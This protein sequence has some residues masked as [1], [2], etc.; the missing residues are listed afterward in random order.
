MPSVC[1]LA[2]SLYTETYGSVSLIF[3]SVELGML[4]FS[5]WWKDLLE[6]RLTGGVRDLLVVL[7]E[8]E[9]YWWNKRLPGGER[10][11]LVEIETYDKDIHFQAETVAYW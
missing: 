8:R 1:S 10:D 3:I 7:V 4:L 6:E 9:T 5:Y 2:S 11:L